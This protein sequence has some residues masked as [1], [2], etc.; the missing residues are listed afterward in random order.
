MDDKKWDELVQSIVAMNKFNFNC[1]EAENK[2]F[3]LFQYSEG[4][5][6]SGQTFNIKL[7][8][9]GYWELSYFNHKEQICRHWEPTY[10]NPPQE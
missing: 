2:E 4:P 8:P 1:Y 9:N 6:L 5:P 10:K 7:Y 3:I